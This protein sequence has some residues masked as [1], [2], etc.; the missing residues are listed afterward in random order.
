MARRACLQTNGDS[1]ANRHL[2]PAFGAHL[3]LGAYAVTLSAM[4]ALL[5]A[6]AQGLGF[7]ETQGRLFQF[8]YGVGFL[9][10]LLLLRTPPLTRSNRALAVL[11]AA[12]L[13]LGLLVWNQSPSLGALAAA[14]GRVGVLGAW[15]ELAGTAL[16]VR[17]FKTNPTGAVSLLHA[18]FGLGAWAGP[19]AMAWWLGKGGSWRDVPLVN[20]GLYAL[21]AGVLFVSRVPAEAP[22]AAP[23]P[24][25]AP[26]QKSHALPWLLGG[27][28][29][30]YISAEMS[31]AG[32]APAALKERFDLDNA[33]A[34][35]LIGYFWLMMASGRLL[36]GLLSRR[37]SAQALLVA[38]SALS[39]LSLLWLVMAPTLGQGLWALW[40]T[41]FFYSGIIAFALALAAGRDENRVQ[42]NTAF[43]VTCLGVGLLTGPPLL[44]FFAER[45]AS[46]WFILQAAAFINAALLVVSVVVWRR[47]TKNP[48]QLARGF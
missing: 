42:Q 28:T 13:A 47:H 20:V 29:V 16:V 33:R 45:A 31:L 9:L 24:T 34:A 3:L 26:P 27:V 1:P 6:M 7:E 10:G 44:G 4:G 36:C 46:L 5:P 19:M 21:A 15:L 41:G 32:W 12:G 23:G 39:S 2:W 37:F 18:T 43:I 40:F 35:G 48:G 30:L 17:L 38:A 8:T 11:S 22:A 25:P 14:T